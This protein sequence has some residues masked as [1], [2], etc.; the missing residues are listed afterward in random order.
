MNKYLPEYLEAYDQGIKEVCK[1]LDLILAAIYDEPEE[2]P[3]T[4][5]NNI[6]NKTEETDIT[7]TAVSAE[8]NSED[9]PVEENADNNQTPEKKK[10]GRP[11]KK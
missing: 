11:A 1:K 8:N 4:D 7:E 2:T 3:E 5:D 9:K 10:R 6:E